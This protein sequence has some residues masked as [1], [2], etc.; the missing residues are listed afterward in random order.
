MVNGW[1]RNSTGVGETAHRFAIA[2][3]PVGGAYTDT[4]NSS[5][6]RPS[7]GRSTVPSIDSDVMDRKGA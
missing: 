3:P 4:S 6:Q 5:L 2:V 1:L 7:N